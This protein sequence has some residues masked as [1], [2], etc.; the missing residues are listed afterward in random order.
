MR[1]LPP[2]SLGSPAAAPAHLPLQRQLVSEEDY[3]LLRDNLQQLGVALEVVSVN[4]AGQPF[5][6]A[7]VRCARRLGGW[8]QGP[9]SKQP[10]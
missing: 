2:A 1:I 9:L 7:K 4:Q 3:L 8:V 6:E 10:A 5:S